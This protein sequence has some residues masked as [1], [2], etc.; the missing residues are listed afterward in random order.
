MRT[1]LVDTGPMVALFDASDHYHEASVYFIRHYQGK[2]VTTL[3]SITETM[4]LLSYS[5]AA[6]TA[7][8]KWISD[9]ALELA[10][11]HK[12]DFDN[13]LKLFLKYYDLP[14]DFADGCLVNLAESLKTNE[15]ATIDKDFNIYRLNGNKK[16][17]VQI[18]M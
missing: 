10:D 8:L 6:Q 4:Y 18:G 13:I 9:G 17:I 16:F 14:M 2:L 3:A 12:Q 15:I 7:F 5:T 11:V 1:C